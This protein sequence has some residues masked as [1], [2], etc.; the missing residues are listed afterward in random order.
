MSRVLFAAVLAIELGGCS[1]HASPMASTALSPSGAGPIEAGRTTIISRDAPN[2]PYV[3]S[4]LAVDPRRPSSMIATAI[5]LDG[6]VDTALYDSQDAGTHWKRIDTPHTHTIDPIVYFSPGGRGFFESEIQGG[7]NIMSSDDGGSTWSAFK[8][9]PMGVGHDRPYIGF[10][11]QGPLK[12]R[13]HAAGF[14]YLTDQRGRPSPALAVVASSDDGATFSAPQAVEVA[15]PNLKR[16]FFPGFDMLPAD[17][18]VTPDGT[19]LL[20]YLPW[21]PDRA[22]RRGAVVAEYDVIASRGPNFYG[23][24]DFSAPVVAA[25]LTLLEDNTY[26]GLEALGGVRA[27][28]DLS[29]NRYRG[30][31]YLVYPDYTGSGIN[32]DVVH[33]GDDG[34]TWSHPVRVNDNAVPA[35]NANPAIW[36]NDRGVVAV[37]WNDRRASRGSACYRLYASASL[38]GGEHFLRNAPLSSDVTCPNAPGN[39]KPVVYANQ[40]WGVGRSPKK[41]I[42][43]LTAAN[44]WPNGGDTQGLQSEPDGTFD[45]AW[46]DGASGVMQLAFTRFTV[47]GSAGTARVAARNRPPPA[48][49]SLASRLELNVNAARFDPTRGTFSVDLQL[50]NVSSGPIRGPFAAVL[51]STSGNLRHLRPANAN[52]T[53]G[54]HSA[55]ILG[56]GVLEPGESTAPSRAAWTFTA[57]LTEKPQYPIF[58][59]DIEHAK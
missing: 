30:R 31:V 19:L 59:F 39:W 7:L 24:L 50:K 12:G 4:F 16:D 52:A 34:R 10:D 42:V 35:L 32:I 6:R 47:A 51:E 2:D 25:R 29:R 21:R 3:E 36:V 20:P 40:N 37:V 53:I 54:E 5:T 43:V 33:S 46:I 38:D 1:A 15:D 45:A 8:Y 23:G 26:R 55:W 57:G 14:V 44:R 22:N 49:D 17:V 13:M 58:V 9:V 28:V 27:A 48:R 41:A 18:L 56:S 11:S